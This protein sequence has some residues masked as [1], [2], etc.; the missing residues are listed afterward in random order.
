MTVVYV[1]RCVGENIW[2]IYRC[3]A[4]KNQ[5]NEIGVFGLKWN[6]LVWMVFVCSCMF[7]K[8]PSDVDD[9]LTLNPIG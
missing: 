1:I 6:W 8:L 7:D 5:T 3:L 9:V 4:W 2:A